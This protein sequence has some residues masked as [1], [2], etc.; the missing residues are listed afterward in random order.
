[1]LYEKACYKN[2]TSDQ[3]L[4]SCIEPSVNAALDRRLE[5]A[6]CNTLLISTCF[7]GLTL[8][9]HR[10]DSCGTCLLLLATLLEHLQSV[11]DL[12]ASSLNKKCQYAESS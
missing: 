1:M 5:T 4:Q 7:S 2:L 12:L 8:V 9:L 10:S 3:L 6:A 11:G